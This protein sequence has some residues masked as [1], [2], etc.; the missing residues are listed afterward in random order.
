MPE[1]VHPFLHSVHTFLL[2]I[3]YVPDIGDTSGKP[4]ELL[5]EKIDNEPVASCC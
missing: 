4:T 5:V 3:C 2:R 1:L